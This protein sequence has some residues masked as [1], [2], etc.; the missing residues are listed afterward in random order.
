MIFICSFLSVLAVNH[1]FLD[2]SLRMSNSIFSVVLFL[3]CCFTFNY[4][5]S[6]C[7][8]A[9]WTFACIFGILFSSAWVFGD[10]L[11]AYDYS[12]ILSWTTWGKIFCISPLFIALSRMLEEGLI[13]ISEKAQEKK[14]CWKTVW[15]T[16]RVFI[17]AWML[18]MVCWIPVWLAAFPGIYAYDAV[19]QTAEFYLNTGLSGHHPIAHTAF[20]WGSFSLGKMLFGTY[21]AGM[22][23]YAFILKQPC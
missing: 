10:N 19:T 20:L 5:I 15:S 1:I 13:R 12:R 23:V 17:L 8:K 2:T 4:A 7:E 22:A 3:W 9:T 21:E 14:C 11:A 16:R 6:K 18:I